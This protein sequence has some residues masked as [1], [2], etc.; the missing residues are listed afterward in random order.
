MQEKTVMFKVNLLVSTLGRESG[1][2][3]KIGVEQFQ[4]EWRV[5]FLISA[6][7]FIF[8]KFQGSWNVTGKE[9][10]LEDL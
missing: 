8:M 9:E 4:S 10:I 7:G 1:E 3:R 2:F 5:S 6:G